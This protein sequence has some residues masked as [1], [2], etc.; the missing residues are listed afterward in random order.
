MPISPAYPPVQVPCLC[1][2]ERYDRLGFL[3]YPLRRGWELVRLLEGDFADN[4]PEKTA[5]FLQSWL[6]FG[7]LIDVLGREVSEED[8]ITTESDGRLLVTTHRL[9]GDI[10]AWRARQEFIDEHERR[11]HSDWVDRCLGVARRC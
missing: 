4:P 3:D 10:I 5:S 11:K 7:L 8:Y 6:Y 1:G 2:T 9:Q